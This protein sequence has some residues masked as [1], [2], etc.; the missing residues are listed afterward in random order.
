MVARWC[1]GPLALLLVA[2]SSALSAQG[3]P[4]SVQGRQDLDFGAMI[5][6]VPTQVSRL[7]AAAAGQFELRGVRNAP[8]TVRLTLPTVMTGPGTVPLEFGPN[9]GGHGPTATI[10]ASQPFDPTQ[11]LSVVLAGNGKYFVFLGGTARPSAQTPSG[12]YVAVVSLTMT[13]VGN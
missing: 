5:A 1:A 8:V 9:D 11:L 10:T 13:Y 2:G 6:G 12:T 4:L 7:D 3:R